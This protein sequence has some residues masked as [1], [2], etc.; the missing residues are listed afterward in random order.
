MKN[1]Y[2]RGNGSESAAPRKEGWVRPSAY[3]LVALVVCN[4]CG[5]TPSVGRRGTLVAPQDAPVT[6]P[7]TGA[8][9]IKETPVTPPINAAADAVQSPEPG[10]TPVPV[11]LPSNSPEV[12]P[13]PSS[14]PN[15]LMWFAPAP[16][17]TA[18]AACQRVSSRPVKTPPT[19][20]TLVGTDLFDWLTGTAL[21]D[22]ILGLLGDDSIFAGDGDDII[23]GGE[24]LDRISGG[25]GDDQL[26]GEAERDTLEGD[27]GNDMIFGGAAADYIRGG[28]GHDYGSG[29]DGSDSIWGG[30]G[31][32]FLEGGLG[33][34]H[35]SGESGDDLVTGGA[36]D[37][38]VGGGLG[39]DCVQGGEGNDHVVGG[40]GSD[41]LEGGEGNDV[42][43][44]N[45]VN[46]AEILAQPS[47]EPALA[48][49]CS[50]QPVLNANCQDSSFA[51]CS[52]D[53][54]DGGNGDDLFVVREGDSRVVIRRDPLGANRLVCDK[55]QPLH[56]ENF[57]ADRI[58][59][60]SGFVIKLEGINDGSSV[61]DTSGCQ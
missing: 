58:I 14:E 10:Q 25:L 17:A 52:Q 29:D 23:V 43:R 6:K 38:V 41:V 56:T 35:V 15:W 44:P 2:R 34:D 11:S 37:D 9:G 1:V 33:D 28:P 30:D 26:F 48:Q 22:V 50:S 4:A 31:D 51:S 3:L 59:K 45:D 61:I 24:G 16:P 27:G 5:A 36:G 55:Q 42:L 60:G 20:G 47:A 21:A 46:C 19:E 8:S 39:D 57:G 32:D 7:G 12:Q 49:W 53:W 18:S 13:T 54:L 40:W